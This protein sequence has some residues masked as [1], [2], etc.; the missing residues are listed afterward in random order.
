MKMHGSTF[1][2]IVVMF[3]MA[4]VIALSMGLETL[5][6][7]LLPVIIGSATFLLAAIGL[8]TDMIGEDEE[9]GARLGERKEAV[10]EPK[11]AGSGYTAIA[12]WILGFFLA[13]YL[14][15]FMLAIPLFILAYM[16]AHGIKW[17]PAITSSAAAS[18]LIY[19]M[20][21]LLLKADLHKG[22]LN[23]L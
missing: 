1:S 14:I 10:E 15:G 18:V 12:L 8:A 4:I 23:I 20:F 7:K 3:L 2:L 9:E 6:L 17:L 16:K 11:K 21:E 13:I 5:K 19:A 22:L